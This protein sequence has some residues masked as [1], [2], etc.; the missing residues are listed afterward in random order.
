MDRRCRKQRSVEA[1]TGDENSMLELY[2]TALRLRRDN[3][4]LGDGTMTWHDAPAGIL[5][6][7]RAPGFVCVVN[8]SDEAYQLPDHTAIQL[9]SGPIADG[10]LEPEHA[11]WLAV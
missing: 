6:F 11:V 10:L 7:H 1:Q 9:A 4:A 5:A 3:P 2:R 8:L